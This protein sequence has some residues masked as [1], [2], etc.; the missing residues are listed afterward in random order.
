MER[1]KAAPEKRS[2]K[3]AERRIWKIGLGS[4]KPQAKRE[5][6]FAITIADSSPASDAPSLLLANEDSFSG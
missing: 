1:K 6:M 3:G 2:S 5:E 4:R